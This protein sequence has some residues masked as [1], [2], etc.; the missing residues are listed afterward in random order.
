MNLLGQECATPPAPYKRKIPFLLSEVN[1]LV[2]V[3]HPQEAEDK[4][5]LLCVHVAMHYS[6]TYACQRRQPSISVCTLLTS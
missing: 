2:P 4:E 3:Q 5:M 1:I 6:M